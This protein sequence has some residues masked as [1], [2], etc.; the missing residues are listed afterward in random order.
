MPLRSP[1]KTWKPRGRGGADNWREPRADEAV[2]YIVTDSAEM[3]PSLDKIDVI[4]IGFE[5]TR[6]AVAGHRPCD[7]LPIISKGRDYT[8]LAFEYADFT[9]AAAWARYIESQESIIEDLKRETET[10]EKWCALAL[11]EHVRVGPSG[12]PA[13]IPDPAQPITALGLRTAV[14]NGVCTHFLKYHG[15]EYGRI[16]TIA[17]LLVIDHRTLVGGR[18]NLGR[19]GCAEV[20]AA[21]AP[22]RSPA[23]HRHDWMKSA[24][25]DRRVC[26]CGESQPRCAMCGGNRDTCGHFVGA[27]AL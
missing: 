5:D 10:R 16:P 21:L 23:P 27:G 3:P 1:F 24:D 2:V 9:P 20:A 6:V 18:N 22:Y 17:E 13:S 26:A 19:I 11:A 4:A 15:F 14:V 25:G 7:V 8:L 12:P